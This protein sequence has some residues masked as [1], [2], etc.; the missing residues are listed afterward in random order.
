MGPSRNI[1]QHLK[2]LSSS[3]S[4]V[5]PCCSGESSASS[6]ST[7]LS[8]M[9]AVIFDGTLIPSEGLA[10]KP[11][12]IFEDKLNSKKQKK[13]KKQGKESAIAASQQEIKKMTCPDKSNSS[14]QS[15]L[16]LKLSRTL[17]LGLTSKERG[18]S[19][20]STERLKAI[21]QQLWLPIETDLHDLDLSSS[22]GSLPNLTSNS[23]FST[24]VLE[25]KNP[26]SV[27][28]CFPS[29]TSFPVESTEEEDTRK[30]KRKKPKRKIENIKEEIKRQCEAE[31]TKKINGIVYARVCGKVLINDEK[32]CPD[33]DKNEVEFEQYWPYTCQ[34]LIQ[35]CGTGVEIERSRKGLKCGEFCE[36]GK[37][38]CKIHT[39]SG[40]KP[41]RTERIMRCIKVRAVPNAKT[42]ALLNEFMGGKR[43][44]Y[45][46]MVE[47]RLENEIDGKTDWKFKKWV[48]G[49]CK[50]ELIT[51]CP[52]FLDSVPT[53]IRKDAVSEYMTGL[54]NAINRRQDLI[55]LEKWKV[56]NWTGY[57]A[58]TIKNPEMKF[59]RKKD[60][61]SI[62]VPASITKI[63]ELE[64]NLPMNLYP[65]S[66]KRIAIHAFTSMLEPIPIHH[67]AKRNK[68]LKMI[69][70]E[71]ILYDW[72]LIKTRTGK[73]YFCFPYSAKPTQSA[74]TIKQV[75]LDGG[76][77]VFQ[78]SYSPQGEVGEYGKDAWKVL[79]KYQDKIRD[80]RKLY[81]ADG[82]D[83]HSEK[84]R[85]IRLLLQEKLRNC[86]QD[87]HCKV[88]KMLCDSYNTIVMPRF[89]IRSM[90]K[91]KNISAS[92]KRSLLALSHS[93]FRQRLID[94]ASLCGT[95]LL[96]PP[97]ERATTM[98]CGF[99]FTPNFNIK[100]SETFWCD[101]CGLKT[102][103][104]PHAARNI[105]IR[106][107]TL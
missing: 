101:K 77:R 96:I 36:E 26:S 82:P 95:E 46:K 27:K 55:N 100:G 91:S 19:A 102:G 86:V 69:L 43:W 98:T 48:E 15:F 16:N 60:Q 103:R 3:G 93:A 73:Y 99:C 5:L 42:R 28:T 59:Q 85:R 38:F 33:H 35:K 14:N 105:F 75:A 74:K 70:Q 13:S 56:K 34:A 92:T 29:S 49:E 52:E 2:Q 24:R 25:V 12:I 50:N 11:K 107:L 23:W 66:K 71:G 32:K 64:P 7:I 39:K 76:A 87:L 62:H 104:D 22:S 44:T 8:R 51:N 72:R 17:G 63:L 68:T 6:T 41:P 30:K 58:K 78:T 94:K 4:P 45:N 54:V 97:N 31:I 10:P 18:F 61:Q 106:Q 57:R 80:V 37:S 47:Q 88:A 40:S 67:R 84:L 79:A 9:A 90:I 83:K 89:G 20:Y 21:S 65:D 81:Y 53:E 1:C